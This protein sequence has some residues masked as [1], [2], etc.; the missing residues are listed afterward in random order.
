M[1]PLPIGGGEDAETGKWRIHKDVAEAWPVKWN[2][3]SFIC[4]L[5]SFPPYGVVP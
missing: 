3:I 2:D 5:M 4:R 1:Q